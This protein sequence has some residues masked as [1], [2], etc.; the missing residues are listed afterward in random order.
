MKAY[1]HPLPMMYEY[2]KKRVTEFAFYKRLILK[3]MFLV[4]Q[5]EQEQK[6]QHKKETREQEPRTPSRL[7]PNLYCTKEIS[8]G[9]EHFGGRSVC[10]PRA[11]TF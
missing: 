4:V 5:D 9:K 11:V 2:E 10:G 7:L 8:R 1:P 6:G 3:D